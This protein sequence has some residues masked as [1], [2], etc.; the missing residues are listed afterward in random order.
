MVY[1]DYCILQKNLLKQFVYHLEIQ[2]DIYDKHAL[3][4]FFLF[5]CISMNLIKR[6]LNRQQ[7]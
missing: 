2:N 4:F 6:K 3:L 1:I 7:A 5:M